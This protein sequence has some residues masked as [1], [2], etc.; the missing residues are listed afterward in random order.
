VKIWLWR[1]Y[2]KFRP[3]PS[4]FLRRLRGVIHVGANSGQ[5]RDSYARRGLNVLWIEP[6]PEVFQMLQQNL[7]GFPAQRALQALIADRD[8]V[9]LELK[10][11]NNQ[12]ASSS[13][14]DLDLHRDIWPDV[15]YERTYATTS[16]TLPSLIRDNAIDLDLYDGLIL[17]T[18]GSE[19]MILRGAAGILR[20]F[21]YI[22][23]EVADFSSYAGGCQ[24]DELDAFLRGQGFTAWRKEK[25]AEHPSGGAYYDVVYRRRS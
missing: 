20:W 18:Q 24:L 7:E 2:E 15:R 19:L 9:P 16:V 21:K 4:R 3:D 11:A 10:V 8:G 23:T 1:L 25:F 22:Q 6:I 14:F 13:I 17:D 12:G 5:E